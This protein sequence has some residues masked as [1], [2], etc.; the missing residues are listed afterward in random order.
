MP[1]PVRASEAGHGEHF[2]VLQHG[3]GGHPTNLALLRRSLAAT[4]TT[5]GGAKVGRIV[6]WDTHA[7]TGL[8]NY[9]GTV[10]CVDAIMVDLLPALDEFLARH[11]AQ[12]CR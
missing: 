12:P 7:I 6:V 4:A 8:M 11:R 9:K 5:S 10:A 1:M 3:I 2:V